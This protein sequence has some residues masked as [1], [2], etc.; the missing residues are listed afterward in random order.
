MTIRG[1]SVDDR[2]GGHAVSPEHVADKILR[3]VRRNR[4]LIYTSPDI[5]ALYLFKRATWWPYSVAM[6]QANVMFTP[7]AAAAVDDALTVSKSAIQARAVASF[8]AHAEQ[9]DRPV[10]FEL[11]EQVQRGLRDD[12]GIG[13]RLTRACGSWSGCRTSWCA[14]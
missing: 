14:P 12:S 3:G 9:P 2:F 7:C 4:F 13:A 5:R 1:C 8:Q 10:E 11:V 6:R